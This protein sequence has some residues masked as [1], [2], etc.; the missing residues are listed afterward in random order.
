MY[1]GGSLLEQLRSIEH[2]YMEMRTSGGRREFFKN[3]W[4]ASALIIIFFASIAVMTYYMAKGVTWETEYPGC[5]PIDR[6]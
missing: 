1:F 3:F 4:C 5:D 2:S 6:R